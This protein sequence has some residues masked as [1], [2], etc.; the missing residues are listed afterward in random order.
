MTEDVQFGPVVLFGHGGT[1][2]E[3]IDDKALVL[4]PL[5]MKLARE[6]M[7][8]TRVFRLLQGFRGK[9][10]VALDAVALTLI[11]VSQLIGDWAEIIE[12][13]INPLLADA[14][15][16]VALDARIRVVEAVRPGAARL[17]IRP[18]PREL[19]QTLTVPDGT[20]F[21]VRPIRPEDGPAVQ[22]LFGKLTPDD[23]RLRFF[24]LM[25]VL[26]A[27]LA[28]RCKVDRGALRDSALACRRARLPLPGV[29]GKFAETPAHRPYPPVAAPLRGSL[30]NP[31]LPIDEQD[32]KDPKLRW[33]MR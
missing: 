8:E 10:A 33:S 30:L 14:Q 18:Y 4:P 32:P 9:P 2:V 21:F 5:N 15:G 26:P 29:C 23:I 16:V 31:F 12:L 6:M 20:S 3:L 11:T 22:A 25:K 13:D 19:E 1:G 28:A 24:T 27:S 7:A 17:A